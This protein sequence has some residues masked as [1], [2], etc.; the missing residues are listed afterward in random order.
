MTAVSAILSAGRGDS[1]VGRK[2]PEAVGIDVISSTATLSASALGRMAPRPIHWSGLVW[3][4][5]LTDVRR[6]S[7]LLVLLGEKT[8]D[9][10][11]NRR[12]SVTTVRTRAVSPWSPSDPAGRRPCGSVTRDT[13]RIGI[14]VS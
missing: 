7:R 6:G 3:M 9:S 1:S 14:W 13:A 4:S 12:E 8:C 11:A 10:L 5:L 2:L